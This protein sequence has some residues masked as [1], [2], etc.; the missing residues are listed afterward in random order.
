MLKGK[1]VTISAQTPKRE[2]AFNSKLSTKGF[3]AAYAK[4]R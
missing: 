2:E 4:I 1:D 3:E